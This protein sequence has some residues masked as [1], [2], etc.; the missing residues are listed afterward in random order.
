MSEDPAAVDESASKSDDSEPEEAETAG[1]DLFEEEEEEE[2]EFFD[3]EQNVEE[4]KAELEAKDAEIEDL[5]DKLSRSRADFQN[6]KKRMQN[7]QEEMQA[8]ATEDLVSRFTKI[9]ENL[10]RA[11]DQDQDADIRPGIQSTLDELDAILDEE[12]VE[13]ISPEPGEAVDPQRHEVMMNVASDQPDGTVADVYQAGYEMAGK[14]LQAAQ[15]T[16]SSDDA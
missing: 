1:T 10:V 5:T 16:V 15:V 2:E 13:I 12:N 3:D 11:L 6:Y 9:R 4:L 8:R 7:K 14:V